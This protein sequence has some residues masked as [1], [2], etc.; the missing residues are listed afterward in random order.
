MSQNDCQ[1]V[2]NSYSL[3]VYDIITILLIMLKLTKSY[4][5]STIETLYN[6]LKLHTNINMRLAPILHNIQL[7]K[8]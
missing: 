5:N 1:I 8:Y 4:T 2:Y 6:C 3:Q 7:C